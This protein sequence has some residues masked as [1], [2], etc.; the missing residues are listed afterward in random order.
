M[1]YQ[2]AGIVR[3]RHLGPPA[4]SWAY[5]LTEEGA[6]LEPVLV[7]LGRWGRSRPMTVRFLRVSSRNSG[8]AVSIAMKMSASDLKAG[9]PGRTPSVRTFNKA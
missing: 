6:A 1:G 3:R 2:A 9:A 5:E 7:A 4:G 8:A